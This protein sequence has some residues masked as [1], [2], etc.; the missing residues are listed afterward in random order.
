MSEAE[1]AR[2]LAAAKALAE[3]G[4]MDDAV[5]CMDRAIAD[6][7]PSPDLLS[8]RARYNFQGRFYAAA[9][10]DLTK[11]L[12]L[13]PDDAELYI[14]RHDALA[15]VNRAGEALADVERALTLRPDDEW[16]RAARVRLLLSA[17]RLD[18]AEAAVK[19]QLRS[20]SKWERD[21]AAFYRACLDVK[22][23]RH[24]AAAKGWERLMSSRPSDDPLSMRARFYWLAAKSADPAFCR[25]H[26][27]RLRPLKGPRLLLCG[28]GLFPPYAAPLD[29]LWAV[30]QCDIVVNNVSGHEMREFLSLYCD[31]VR[32]ATYDARGDDGFWAQKIVGLME[33]GKIVGFVTRG[34]PLVFG[35]LA[36][37][38][39]GAAAAAK[40]QTQCFG[41]LSCIEVLLTAASRSQE[42]SF[43]G[44]Q[45]YD[46]EALRKAE[47]LD[48]THPLIAFSY[49][50]TLRGESLLRFQRTLE[51]F[52]PPEHPC[53]VFGPKYEAP[54]ITL[55]LGALAR[56]LPELHSGL[57]LYLPEKEPAAP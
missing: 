5:L 1:R 45:A 9:V 32:P 37:N 35:G 15:Q 29:A 40:A 54:P 36:N 20:R 10:D 51:R 12:E 33:G 7:G 57:T 27:P 2:R 4:H 19:R 24:A 30:R 46:E 22:R 44:V 26:L 43:G 53:L 39:L 3:A 23:G 48:P 25:K 28:V 8:C 55:T 41:A 17:A 6:L 13:S 56:E 52:F 42:R 31:D 16:L 14:Q 11:A 18:E 50:E 21:E 47:A 34:H 49:L 38:L